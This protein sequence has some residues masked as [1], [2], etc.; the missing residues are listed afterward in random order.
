LHLKLL[1]F[2]DECIEDWQTKTKGLTLTGFGSDHHID[3][4]L[5]KH[6]RMT[7]NI[8]WLFEAIR[9]KGLGQALVKLELGP[10]FNIC[11]LVLHFDIDYNLSTPKFYFH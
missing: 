9:Y 6:E 5:Q 8:R 1:D 10:V 4:L 11:L 2:L 7:L 3:V